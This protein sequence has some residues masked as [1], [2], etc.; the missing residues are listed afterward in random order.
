MSIYD[1]SNT[2]SVCEIDNSFTSSEAT[3]I[4]SWTGNPIYD[5]IIVTDNYAWSELYVQILG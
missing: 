4:A 2:S 3:V 1:Q 5:N